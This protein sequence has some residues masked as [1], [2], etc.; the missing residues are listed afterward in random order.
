VRVIA[1]ECLQ[2]EPDLLVVYAGNNEVIGPYGPGTVFD[3]FLGSGSLVRASIRFKGTRL[4]QLAERLMSRLGASA[5][6]PSSWGG[7]SM[8]LDRR[9]KADDPRLAAVYGHYRDNLEAVIGSA[10]ARGVPVV[11]VTVATNLRGQPPF[12]SSSLEVRP[13]ADRAAFAEAMSV[14]REAAA[15]GRWTEALRGFDEALA[16]DDEVAD[17][18]FEWAGSALSVGRSDEALARFRSA[19]DL[20]SLRFRADSRLTA[21][22]KEVGERPSVI[23]LDGERELLA[24]GISRDGVLGD[25]FFFEHV[26][27]RPEGNFVLASAIA[28]AMME[29]LGADRPL[30]SPIMSRVAERLGLSAWYLQ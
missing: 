17:L 9:V 25:E 2:F 15:A 28:E 29:L 18:H 4:G 11:L 14:G 24:A 30:P 6:V 13:P 20:D 27:L 10:G 8:F 21:I 7:L 26:H 12:A 1:E 16:I 19:R 3:R 22:A 23:L 5:P